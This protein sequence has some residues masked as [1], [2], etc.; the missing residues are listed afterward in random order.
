MKIYQAIPKIM[1]E[2]GAIGKERRNTT[3][4]AGYAFRGIDD[5]Y[6]AIQ[7]ALIKYGVFFTPNVLEHTREERASRSGGHLI[8]TILKVEYSFYADDGSSFKTIVI[9]EA[10]D[11]GDKSANKA[12][13][14]ALKYALLQVFCVPTE[15]A[16]D[17]ENFSPEIS[18]KIP[19]PKELIKETVKKYV[20]KQSEP[21]L[22]KLSVP[23][24][25]KSDADDF[26]L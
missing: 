25:P 12:M 14:A 20:S 16:I 21:G 2:I 5:V 23:Y 10:M 9:G 18:S 7:P 6:N 4:G 3:Q 26:G 11:S 13:S 19:T 22:K 15:G 8:Y 24:V 1:S 17:T